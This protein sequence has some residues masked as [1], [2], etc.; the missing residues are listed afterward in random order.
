[1]TFKSPCI[2]C[3]S[4]QRIK[5]TKKHIVGCKG[6]ARIHSK[7]IDRLNNEWL[8]ERLTRKCLVIL[9]AVQHAATHLAK[10]ER[11]RAGAGGSGTPDSSTVQ[12][13]LR[14]VCKRSAG[15]V[16]NSSDSESRGN[17]S[18]EAGAAS[19]ISGSGANVTCHL[20]IWEKEM[21]ETERERERG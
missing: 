4:F 8:F 11:R 14:L 10:R 12:R 6:C 5:C 16:T 18:R 1:M 9:C 17:R 20:L 3:D 13:P 21:G 7:N 19:T 2:T 15:Q